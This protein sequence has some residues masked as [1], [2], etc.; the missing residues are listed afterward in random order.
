MYRGAGPPIE[1]IPSAVRHFAFELLLAA[2]RAKSAA[3]PARQPSADDSCRSVAEALFFVTHHPSPTPSSV[4]Q[5]QSAHE[6]RKEH[7][8]TQR[9]RGSAWSSEERGSM[10]TLSYA[11]ALARAVRSRLGRLNA[12]WRERHSRPPLRSSAAH[13]D[14]SS[15]PDR[16]HA[17]LCACD[18]AVG[19]SEFCASAHH[20]EHAHRKCDVRVRP[21]SLR[22]RRTRTCAERV[23]P[24]SRVRSTRTLCALCRALSF[25]VAQSPGVSPL[26][27]VFVTKRRSRVSPTRTLG[28]RLSASG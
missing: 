8:P 11:T 25:C 10:R 1:A 14:V 9:P 7:A 26:S 4:I 6:A 19:Q 16:L 21:Y 24:Y 5:L 27:A 2:S 18:C 15:Y 12:C 13:S 22:V 17:T 28:K 23:P 3:Q 20:T